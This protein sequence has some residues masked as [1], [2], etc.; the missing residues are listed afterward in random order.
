MPFATVLAANTLSIASTS[1]NRAIEA[2]QEPGG[3][4][5]LE[6]Q[7]PGGK[8]IARARFCARLASRLRL[9]PA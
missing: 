2:Q 6:T 8:K 4:L 3:R 1:N 7:G 9:F 5:Q